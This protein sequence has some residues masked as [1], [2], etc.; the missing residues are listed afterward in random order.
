MQEITP[1]LMFEGQAEE[2]IDFYTSLFKKS[3]ILNITRYGPNEAGAEGTVMHATFSLN[4]QKFMCIDSNV[5]HAFTF[6]PA[7]S[8]YVTCETEG[9]VDE[10]YD[11]LSSGGQVRMPLAPYPFSQ[12]FA[13]LDDRFGVSWQLSLAEGASS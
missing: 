6:T 13:W 7:I 10:L 3:K 9:E 4:G 5:E 1:F 11:Q 8:L 12:K 2:A